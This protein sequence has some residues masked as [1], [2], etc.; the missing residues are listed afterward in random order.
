MLQFYLIWSIIYTFFCSVLVPEGV[1]IVKGTK[2][3]CI[4]IG[5]AED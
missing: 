1:K 2:H 3:V 4:F 5:S